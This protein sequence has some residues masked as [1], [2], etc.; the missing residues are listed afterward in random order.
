MGWLDY[1][2]MPAM[3]VVAGLTGYAIPVPAPPPPSKALKVWLLP[4]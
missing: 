3:A 2:V 1:I 4:K